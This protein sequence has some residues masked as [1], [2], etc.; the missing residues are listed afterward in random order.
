MKN[1]A[2]TYEK[3]KQRCIRSI[4]A[5]QITKKQHYLPV[6]YLDAFTIDGRLNALSL[7]DK[8]KSYRAKPKEVC[9]VK[10]G[11]LYAQDSRRPDW[12]ESFFS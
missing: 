4:E 9:Y 12:I 5:S 7:K 3:I 10:K 11:F 8:N 1:E 6:A 2:E